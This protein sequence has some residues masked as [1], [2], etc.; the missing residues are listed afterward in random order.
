MST[1]VRDDTA[2]GALAPNYF[3]H[4]LP[5]GL[6]LVGQRMPSLASVTFGIQLAAGVKEEP[7]DQLGLT[8]LL[9]EMLFQGTEQRDV[10]QLTDDF[11]AIGARRGGESST[12][13]ARYSAQIVGNRLDRALELMADVL[14][15]PTIPNAE[16]EQMRNVQLQEIRRRDD[17]PMR[18]IFDHVRE[19]FYAGT[20]LGRTSLGTH[21][22]VAHLEPDHLRAFWRERYRP[23]G[24]LFAIAGNFDWDH[25]VERVGAFLGDWRGAA[26][27]SPANHPNPQAGVTIE[28]H[29]GNQEHIGMA[30]P[31]PTFGDPDYYAA[32]VASEIFGGGMT[33]RLF[34]E[35]REKRGL[36]YSVMASFAPI[37]GY[38][39]MFL[40]GG[41]TPDKA[42]ETVQVLLDELRN[43]GTNGVTQDELDRAKVQLKSEIVMRGESA[44]ARMGAISRSWWYKRELTTIQQIKE[45]IDA[46]SREQITG[47][48][49]RFPPLDRLV[50]AAIGPRS[51]EEL[52]GNA[53]G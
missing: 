23:E 41:T 18:R 20:H 5:N 49:R 52:V 28:R 35:V 51:R 6:Q 7:D 53:L 24:A 14:L 40:Y 37:G 38:G 13:V 9:A 36:V 11:E 39:A 32:T 4:T 34:R 46:V 31:F 30:F 25:V 42:H 15:H 17:E 29:E 1:E 2:G 44:S 12:D 45:S 27:Q 16:F 43:L 22:T 10:R 19:R 26:P 3:R 21:E 33:S 48:M 50:I 8:N 47:L